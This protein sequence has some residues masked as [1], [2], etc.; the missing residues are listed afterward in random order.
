VA[1]AMA[2]AATATLILM[3]AGLSAGVVLLDRERNEARRQRDRAQENFQ[4]ALR[5]VDDYFT[6]VSEST[7]LKSPL[8]GLQPLRRQLLE[9]ALTYYQG[10]AEQHSND[11]ALQAELARASDRVG[12]IREEIGAKPE[13]LAAYRRAIELWEKLRQEQPAKAAYR[14][15]LAQ[16]YGNLGSLQSR[17]GAEGEA[18]LASLQKACALAE[19][20]T[21]SYPDQRE[22]QK[23][24][25]RAAHRLGVW[26]QDH[27]SPQ[28]LTHLGNALKVWERLA[29]DEPELEIQVASLSMGLGYYHAM[30]GSAEEAL[31][32]HGRARD[33]AEKWAQQKPTDSRFRQLLRRVY[34]NL[35]YVHDARTGR[36]DQARSYYAKVLELDEQLA[37]E[38]P[39]VFD[40]QWLYAGDVWQ[41]ADLIY[42]RTTDY[43]GVARLAQQA[44]RQYERLDRE[45]PHDPQVQKGLRRNSLLLG[46]AQAK[47]GRTE[48]AIRSLQRFRALLDQ[49]EQDPAALAVE[50][51]YDLAGYHAG[52]GFA[53][54]HIGQTAEALQSLEQAVGLYRRVLEHSPE[55]QKAV[56]CLAETCCTLGSLQRRARRLAEAENS[57]KEVRTLLTKV[58]SPDCCDHYNQAVAC[59]QLTLIAEEANKR[60]LADEAMGALRR[61]LPAGFPRVAEL[62]TNPDL[63]PLRSRK[64]FQDLLTGTGKR[65]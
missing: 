39:A 30:Q 13:A 65:Q 62:K 46:K 22:Y 40:Y 41:M 28:A 4:K 26:Y 43:D 45:Y 12:R 34:K 58:S 36:Y 31:A 5:V 64:D 52:L 29:K 53:Q 23:T 11:P 38:N 10:F 47:A 60:A 16:C 24:L 3:V 18:A 1:L 61:A 56:R 17:S 15:E 63:D 2:S 9:T 32:F 6:Q 48:E 55:H 59:A 35:G 49:L 14:H 33:I 51:P 25:A 21:G 7:L 20:L 44:L 42:D 19:D 54:Q 37:R 50:E 27:D 8:P 57:F